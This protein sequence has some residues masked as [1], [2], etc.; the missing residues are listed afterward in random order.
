DNVF[1]FKSH[2]KFGMCEGSVHKSGSEYAIVQ[3]LTFKPVP[4]SLIDRAEELAATIKPQQQDRTPHEIISEGGRHNALVREAG[5]ILRVTEMEKS[6]L[7]AHLEDFNE[8]WCEPPLP[9]DEV[10][11]VAMSCN[12][13]PDPEE[14]TVTISGSQLKK[15][16]TDWREH[17]HSFDEM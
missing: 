6:V 4:D 10:S 16:V 2:R 14:P 12:W 7:T 9:E 17:Y 13:Q 1:E 3:N 15:T 8:K 11:R 5:R